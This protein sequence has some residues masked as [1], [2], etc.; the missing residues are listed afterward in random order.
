MQKDCLY[1]FPLNIKNWFQCIFY[2]GNQFSISDRRSGG[3][4][5]DWR[6]EYWIQNL[7]EDFIDTKSFKVRMDNQPL[8]LCLMRPAS[9]F[10]FISISPAR[11]VKSNPKSPAL[12]SARRTRSISDPRWEKPGSLLHVFR[13]KSARMIRSSGRNWE[14]SKLSS[15]LIN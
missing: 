4:S 8:A 14:R 3:N 6:S 7:G 2:A 12:S 1:G 15:K 5:L 9:P 11:A 10:G 13:K